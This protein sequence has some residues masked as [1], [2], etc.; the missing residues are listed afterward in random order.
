[1]IA[2]YFAPFTKRIC[3]AIFLVG[4]LGILTKQT[5]AA[6]FSSPFYLKRLLEQIVSL[7]AGSISITV[8][9]GLAMGSVMTL[10]FGYGLAKFGGTL[11]VPGVVA[12]SLV[13]EMAPIF[14]S[15]LVAGRIGS[16]MAAEIGSMNVT[17]QVDALRAL[18][19]S[20]VRVLVVP[21]FWAA[22][23]SLPLLT[24][25]SGLLGIW[26]GQIICMSEFEIPSGF[27]FNRVLDVVKMH[28]FTSGLLKA[29]FFGGIIAMVGCY[30]GLHTSQGTRGVGQSTTWVVVTSSILILISDFFLSKI[31]LVL[32]VH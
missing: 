5:L 12:L 19:T 16:G 11:Y 8:V 30:R 9:I 7:G 3:N 28:D 17:Q 27:Y 18:G 13:R 6:T 21:R 15:L 2:A 20:P 26:G 23:I 29:A 1:M 32:W 14:T 10:N 25:L 4:Q 22:I 31:F 24:S